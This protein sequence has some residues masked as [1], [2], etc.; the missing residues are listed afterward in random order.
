MKFRNLAAASAGL[1]VLAFTSLAQVTAIE[2]DVKGTDGAPLKAAVINIE[3]TDIKGHYTVKTDK[4][5]HYI[6]TGLPMGTYNVFLVVEGKEVDNVKGVKTRPG[7]PTRE[8]FNQKAASAENSNKQAEYQ[9]ALETG[10]I[11]KDLER[12]LTPEQKEQLKKDMEKKEASMKKNAALNSAYNDGLAALN[13]KEYDKAI[14]NLK[15]LRNSTRRS[16]RCGATW[17]RR[18][19]N[20]PRRRP[21][22]ISIPT[23]RRRSTRMAKPSR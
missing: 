10:Q 21:A 17:R 6:Y 7:D 23:C 15:R 2:G 22:P 11:S 14:E 1:L 3:R 8:D 19:P 12:Q 4:K 18:I 16:S 20:S 13:A 9:K 5:G